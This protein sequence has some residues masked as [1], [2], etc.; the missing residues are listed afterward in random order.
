M[1][2]QIPEV[3]VSSL[4][5]ELSDTVV[6]DVREDDEW[7]AGHIE[8]ATHLPMGEVTARLGELPA[9]K[10]MLVV[11]RSGG[12]SAQVTGFLQTQGKDAVNLAGG[13]RSW[14]AA[15]RP[16]T[17]ETPAAPTVI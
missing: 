9:D 7:R 13:M 16:M 6:L 4:P 5:T 15:G 12:R 14:Q 17:T 2:D 10:R 1:P 11:C 3:E 8:G